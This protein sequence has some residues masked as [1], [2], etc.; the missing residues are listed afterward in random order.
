MIV[1]IADNI[2]SPL[3]MDTAANYEAVLAG[4]STLKLHEGK[5]GV[6]EPFM[7]SLFEDGTIEDGFAAMGGEVQRYSRFEQLC[8]LSADEAL[9]QAPQVDVASKRTALVI[10]TTK[11]NVEALDSDYHGPGNEYLGYSAQEIADYFGFTTT[12]IVVS[13]A[14]ISGLCAQIV[15]MRSLES[16]RYDTVVVVG[17]DVQ[18][19]FIVTGF[20]SFKALSQQQ[21][22]PFDINR[23]GLNLGEAAATV[24]YQ[25][26]DGENH[27]GWMA[28]SGAIRNDANHISGPSRTGEGSYRAMRAVLEGFDISQIGLINVHGTSTLY[29]DEMEAIA[30]SR[31][32]LDK[33]PVN[34]LKGYYGHTMGAAGVLEAV[35]SMHA[36]DHGIVLGTRGYEQCGT[37]VPVNVSNEHRYTSARSFVKLLSGFGG[38]NAAM[39]FKKGGAS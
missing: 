9:R 17:A 39:L 5:W 30:L 4:R 33:T 6:P 11:G 23:N 13:N 32:A 10:S 34:T 12:P 19:R 36:L 2:T 3:G 7:A 21:C 14:C 37:S 35:L 26:A 20:Q 18:S 28:V 27:D 16:G 15:A 8:I 1:K 31:M 29:N 22:K 24:I 38:C 25:K